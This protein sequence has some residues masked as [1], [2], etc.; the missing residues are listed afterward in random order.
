ME[1]LTIVT[2]GILSAAGLL[3]AIKNIADIAGKPIVKKA[4]AAFKKK[5]MLTAEEKEF[6]EKIIGIMNETLPEILYQHD[7][8][9][10]DTYKADRQKYLEDIRGEVLKQI[11]G[12]LV[13]VSELAL[14]YKSLEISAKDVLRE[15][16][17]CLYENNKDRKKLKYF[18]RQAL[19]QYYKDYKAM[20]GNS[21]IDLIYGRME[22]WD[23]EDDD[24]N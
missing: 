15:K 12:E 11:N 5:V 4:D 23:T 10:R 6:K 1:W 14:Q 21:Y 16:I 22:T 8:Q 13:Q 3:V 20:N 7:L 17:V 18:E 9:T 19:K 24:Y 2:G